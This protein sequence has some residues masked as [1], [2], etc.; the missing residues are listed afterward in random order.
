VALFAELFNEMLVR[1]FAYCIYTALLACPDKLPAEPQ[2]SGEETRKKSGG[3][4]D[5]NKSQKSD[6]KKTE[7]NTDNNTDKDGCSNGV[8]KETDKD[9]TSDTEVRNFFKIRYIFHSFH[10]LH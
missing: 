9:S 10:Q 1:D 6:E 7:S 2:R 3:W 5:N 4:D 8:K